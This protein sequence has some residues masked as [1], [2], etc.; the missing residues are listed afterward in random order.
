RRSQHKHRAGNQNEPANKLL[1]ESSSGNRTSCGTRISRV[2]LRVSQTVECHGGRS[3]GNH[4]YQNP[5]QL[6]QPRH[7][8]RSQHGATKCKGK[9]K[10]RVLPLDHLESDGNAAE[11]AHRLLKHEED[12]SGD[13]DRVI[14]WVI[15]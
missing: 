9:G 2:N 15:G 8:A 13:P 14:W 3:R 1:R 11:D 5:S 7:T 6:R 4:T 12:Y 10:D